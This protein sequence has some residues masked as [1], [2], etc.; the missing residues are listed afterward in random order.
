MTEF[1]RILAAALASLSLRATH[2]EELLALLNPRSS[3]CIYGQW[4]SLATLRMYASK[5][6]SHIHTVFVYLYLY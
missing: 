6:T 4:H 2:G 3:L 5:G 1:S